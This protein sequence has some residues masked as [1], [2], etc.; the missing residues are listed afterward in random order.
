MATHDYVLDNATGAN[1]RSDLN[2]AL[3][4]IV[5]NNSSSSEPS[6][7]YA[8]QWW[9]DTNTNILKLRNSANDGWINLL[10]LSGGIDV[11]AASNFAAA[12]T[13]TD[14]VTFDG[15]TAGREIVFDRSD[16]ALEFADNAKATFGTGADLELVHDT[17]ESLISNVNS[18]V[19]LVLKSAASAVIKHDTETMAQFIGDGAVELYHDNAKK[20]ETVSGG[21]TVTGTCTATDFAGDGSNLTGISGGVTSDGQGNTVAGTNAGASF[22]GTDAEANT[23][24][25][26]N[27]GNLIS[28]GDNNTSIGYFSLDVTTTG[29]GNTALGKGT[30]GSN[31][32]ASNNTAVGVDTL[33]SNTTGTLNTAV[34][35]NS[36]DANTT[37]NYNTAVGSGSLGVNTTGVELTAV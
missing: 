28:T 32:T 4:A 19:N 34:G 8:Y 35:S 36:L 23:L 26:R 13:F 5:S 2:N 20:A 1:F 9:A 15:A 7:K 31:T 18:G 10:T 30:L 3:A 33:I 6:T 37:G 22:S 11:D 14:D 17:S 12:V 27:S 16:N 25:C 29:S 24:V 21:F